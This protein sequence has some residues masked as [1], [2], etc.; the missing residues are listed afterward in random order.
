MRIAGSDLDGDALELARRHLQQAGLSGRIQL[1]K[2]DLRDVT[3][4]E[5]GGVF[6]CNPPYG[7][8]LGDRKAAAAVERQLYLLKQRCPGWSLCAISAD[9]SFERN[10]GR[11][12]DRKRRYYNGRLECEFLTWMG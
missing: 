11:R 9:M 3:R 7:E 8:R 4:G 6:L 12:A 10:A 1:E 5:E 2:K